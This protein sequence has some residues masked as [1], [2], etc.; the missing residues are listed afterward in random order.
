VR[1]GRYM[2]IRSLLLR[3]SYLGVFLCWIFPIFSFVFTPLHMLVMHTLSLSGRTRTERG[4]FT[5]G[6]MKQLIWLLIYGISDHC[7]GMDFF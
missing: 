4:E 1:T 3:A 6:G 7:H 2:G 5:E